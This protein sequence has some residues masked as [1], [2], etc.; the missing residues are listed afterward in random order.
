MGGCQSVSAEK[1]EEKEKEKE[2]AP[3]L[4]ANGSSW[5]FRSPTVTPYGEDPGRNRMMNACHTIRSIPGT[6]SGDGDGDG[7]GDQKIEI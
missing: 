1:E 2:P 5:L 6:R 3:F 4:I 7:D